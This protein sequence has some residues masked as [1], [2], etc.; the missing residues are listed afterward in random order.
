MM[1]FEILGP[2]LIAISMSLG[3]LC[4]LIWAVLSG[5]LG[6]ADQTA[7]NFLRMEIGHDGSGKRDDT[8]AS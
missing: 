8:P 7:I 4:V 3:A 6:E 1:D 2:L 5:A